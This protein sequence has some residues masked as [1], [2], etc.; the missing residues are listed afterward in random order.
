MD[1]FETEIQKKWCRYKVE[2]DKKKENIR[3]K[4]Y[5]KVVISL[6]SAR[7]LKTFLEQFICT[8]FLSR[9]RKRK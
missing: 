7:G 1:E 5:E 2:I 6:N 4:V 3:H 9:K 8:I